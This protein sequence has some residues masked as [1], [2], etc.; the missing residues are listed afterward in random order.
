MGTI[1]INVDGET[2]TRF[3]EVVFKEKGIGKGK[4]GEA[5][6]EALKK[7]VEDKQQHEIRKRQLE[8]M[9]KGLPIGL[10]KFNRDDL[11]GRKF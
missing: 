8:L 4:L 7:W 10:K 11:Y 2:E 6:T 3:R 1:T 5:V 9:K